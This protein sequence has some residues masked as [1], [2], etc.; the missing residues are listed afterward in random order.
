MKRVLTALALVPPAS[1]VILWA[2]DWLFLAV[3]AL[4]AV[5]CFSEFSAM[6][7]A[8]G[9]DRPGLAGYAAGLMLLVYPRSDALLVTL[10]AVLALGLA[11]RSE[12][13]PRGLPAAAALVLGVVYVFGPWRS[14]L[15]LRAV[16]PYWLFLALGLN[17]VGDTAA[18]YV[19][20]AIGRHKLAPRLSPSKSWEGS[21]ASLVAG[22]AFG[23]FWLGWLVPDVSPVLR[24]AISAAGN[25]SGQFGDL[26]ESLLKRGAG[27]KDSSNRLPG[28]G[29]WLD[30]LD[31]SLF[32][33][34]VMHFLLI[35]L[36]R[37][38]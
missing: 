11:L 7:A 9:F 23:F 31:G 37:V 6:V 5:A 36:G 26:A 20:R 17:W 16:S 12:L 1:Y 10:I 30:R 18:Y 28:H 27:L 29:G 8:H 33:L 21:V 24:L 25:I 4:V 13:L 3:T 14:A 22:M 38:V 15:A 34:P 19:G 32:T 2:P 35:L